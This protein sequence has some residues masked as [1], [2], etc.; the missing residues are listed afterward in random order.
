MVISIAEAEER[1]E[2]I[3]KRACFP[4]Y[5]DCL[6]VKVDPKTRLAFVVLQFKEEIKTPQT[7]DD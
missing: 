1:A 6:V 3:I 2:R 4:E 5:M 7:S